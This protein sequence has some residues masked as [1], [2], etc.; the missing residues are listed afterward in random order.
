MSDLVS[1]LVAFR[2]IGNKVQFS[3]DMNDPQEIHDYVWDRIYWRSWGVARKEQ[4]DAADR[5]TIDEKHAIRAIKLEREHY[6]TL[7]GYSGEEVMI[8]RM[9]YEAINNICTEY[10]IKD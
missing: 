9:M 1:A 2:L 7:C 4:G 6:Y 3:R 10:N 5:L 8:Y